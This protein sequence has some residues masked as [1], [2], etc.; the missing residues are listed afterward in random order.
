MGQ[1]TLNWRFYWNQLRK[2]LW[3]IIVI[4][5]ISLA[6]GAYQVSQTRPLYQASTQLLVQEPTESKLNPFR[7]PL[8]VDGGV[9]KRTQLRLIKSRSLAIVVVQKLALDQHPEFMP[10]ESQS[11]SVG[12][13]LRQWGG[14]ALRWGRTQAG[15]LIAR[16]RNA[17]PEQASGKLVSR[18]EAT[19]TKAATDESSGASKTTGDSP[20]RAED[21]PA[22]AEGESPV[23]EGESAPPDQ[24]NPSP[25]QKAAQARVAHLLLKRLQVRP[26]PLASMVNVNFQ[27]YDPQLAADVANTL[28]GLYVDESKKGRFDTVKEAM[29]WL[30]NRV[31][32]M[33][34]QAEA[35]QLKLQQYK[36]EHGIYSL[37]DRLPGVMQ[38]M[39]ALNASLTEVRTQRIEYETLYG[40]MQRASLQD[41]AL[42]W[43]PTVVGNEFIQE[44]K[45]HLA[46]LQRELS[47]L[48]KKYGAGHPKVCNSWPMSLPKK[49]RFKLRYG[50]SSS[51]PA[52]SLKCSKRVRRLGGSNLSG[53]NRKHMT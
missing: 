1:L 27:A 8:A 7:D 47:Q 14:D 34:G 24:Q 15:Y 37:D 3:L 29:D 50:R 6:I 33:R 12:F 20:A 52:R 4:I 42:E 16:L 35:S 36:K 39:A 9:Y 28:S 25:A 41:A 51:P 17:P 43:M 22:A 30:Q 48:N 46:G 44:L 19:K 31:D 49:S 21:E 26:V 45:R 10:S 13:L 38:E 5:L 32:Q 23:A 40:E 11:K 53:S 2:R 18:G